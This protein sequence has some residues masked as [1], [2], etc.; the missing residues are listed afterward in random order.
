METIEEMKQII[1]EFQKKLS[2][3]SISI[4]KLDYQN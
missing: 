4:I 2:K 1:K 3:E